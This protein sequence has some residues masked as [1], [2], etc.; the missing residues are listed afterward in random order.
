VCISCTVRLNGGTALLALFVFA[1]L[2]LQ[3]DSLNP[4]ALD[5]Q[6]VPRQITSRCYALVNGLV[7]DGTG[8]A[9]ID[10]GGVVIRGKRIIEVGRTDKITIPSDAE[11]VDVHGAAI[12]PGFVNAHV[13]KAFDEGRLRAWA[14]NGVTTVRDEAILSPQTLEL[15]IATRDTARDKPAYARLITAGFMMTVPGG[16]GRLEVTSAADA[17]QKVFDQLDRGIDLVKLALE[18]G[19][20]GH[21]GLPKLSEEELSA[22]VG[23][24]HERGKLVSAHITQSFY[25]GVVVQAGV[26]DVAHVA[27]DPVPDAVL[28]MMVAKGIPLVPTITIFRN[29]NAPVS[30]CIDNLRRFVHKGGTVALGDDFGGGPGA[31]EEGIPFYELNCMLE[32]GMTPLQIIAACTRN[33]ARVADVDT[34]VGTLEPG[35]NADLLVVKGDPLTS[36]DALSRIGLVIH[37]GVNIRYGN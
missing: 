15:A 20:A 14:W 35:K 26:D 34:I 17:R 22:I 21:S 9:A 6:W 13:H 32:A 2:A 31:F 10:K 16:Y 1:A 4:T 25:W 33:A 24:A 3:C 23:A 12:L 37:D 8:A 30:I 11:V 5:D 19:V 29:Y 7:I 18:D 28:D 27:F 36:L